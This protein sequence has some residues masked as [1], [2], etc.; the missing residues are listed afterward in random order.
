MSRARQSL[1]Q[2][3]GLVVQEKSVPPCSEAIIWTIF[4]CSSAL[5]SV[6]W[7][8]SHNVGATR[9]SSFEYLLIAS[10]CTASASSIRA[11][12]TP[13]RDSPAS[14]RRGLNYGIAAKNLD[15]TRLN[16]HAMRL[17]IKK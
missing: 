3:P 7:N 6:P 5:A 1:W 4:A 8:S 10:I 14:G 13:V 16:C 2:S 9:S 17:R 11:T 15:H 12:G